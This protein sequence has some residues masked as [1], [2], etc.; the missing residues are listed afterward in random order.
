MAPRP[1]ILSVKRGLFRRD[2]SSAEEADA[3][4][5]AMRP[6]VLK[7][8]EY[9]CQFCGFRAQK[10]QEVHHLDDDHHHNDVENLITACPLCHMGHHVGLAGIKQAGVII[11]LPALSQA[12]LNA[13]VR[14]L[15]IA[16]ASDDVKMKTIAVTLTARLHKCAIA[17]RRI[18]NTSDPLILGDYLLGL[19]DETY[20]RRSEIL[21]DF[22]LLPLRANFE[23]QIQYWVKHTYKNVPP[24]T[25]LRVAESKADRILKSTA[26]E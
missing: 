21:K 2:D 15:W 4:F 3:A 16:E 8:D 22:R 7:R 14:T 23:N 9:R 17:A 24:K 25:W 1:I 26:E 11:H 5:K 18:L 12:E 10:W 6:R 19:D 20:G 13:L